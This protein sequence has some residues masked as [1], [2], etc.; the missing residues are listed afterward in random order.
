MATIPT[1][2]IPT[3]SGVTLPRLKPGQAVDF[4]FTADVAL[5]V[6][7]QKEFYDQINRRWLTTEDCGVYKAGD[8][9]L[10]VAQTDETFFYS[11]CV[12]SDTSQSGMRTIIVGSTGKPPDSTSFEETLKSDPPLK[13]LFCECWPCA[14]RLLKALVEKIPIPAP[15][16]DFLGKLFDI[17]DEAYKR[18]C[19]KK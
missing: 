3:P 8:N 5:M 11:W 16:K 19:H 4:Q 13:E 2:Q 9:F 18:L 6:K 1:I 17:G 15:V 10:G 7:D 12:C 14:E